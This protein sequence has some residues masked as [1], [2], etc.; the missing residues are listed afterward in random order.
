MQVGDLIRHKN[1]QMGI[2]M[3]FEKRG[4]W[5]TFVLWLGDDEGCW[6]GKE[7]LEVVCK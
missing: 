6:T 5:D 7:Y 2:I 1:G 3:R 4:L